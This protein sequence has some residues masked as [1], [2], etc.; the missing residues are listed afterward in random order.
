[1]PFTHRI[2][3]KVFQTMST[4]GLSAAEACCLNNSEMGDFSN[5][6]GPID[7]LREVVGGL[8]PAFLEKGPSEQYGEYM[9]PGKELRLAVTWGCNTESSA[10]P[11]RRNKQIRHVVPFHC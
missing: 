7:R 9:L 8:G 11:G 10:K 4:Y 1:M 2:P 5:G 6:E 3:D